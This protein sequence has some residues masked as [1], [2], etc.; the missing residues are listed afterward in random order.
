[1]MDQAKDDL[2]LNSLP[3]QKEIETEVRSKIR[4]TYV[5]H[6]MGGMTLPMY[7]IHSNKVGKDHGIS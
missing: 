2:L 5:G 3:S 4:I 6:S 1:M 7:L